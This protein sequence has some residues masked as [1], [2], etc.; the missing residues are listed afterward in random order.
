LH[1]IFL[2][3]WFGQTNSSSL[4]INILRYF[5]FLFRIRRDIRLF[6]HSTYSQYTYR[7]IPRILSI[8]TDSFRVFS[9][10]DQI[11]STYSQYTNRFIPH[12]LSIQTAKF[13]SNIYLIPRIFRIRIDFFHVFSVYEQIHSAYSQYT[14]RFIPRTLSIRTDSFR[15]FRECAQIILNIRN[16]IIFITAFKGILL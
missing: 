12:I 7:F 9:V 8:R 4:L 16:W 14:N 3:K 15:V 11:H 5:R 6:V 2:F 1:E 13:I 10:H